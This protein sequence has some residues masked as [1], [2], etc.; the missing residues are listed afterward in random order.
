MDIFSPSCF[1]STASGLPPAQVM[2]ES[3]DESVSAQVKG[4]Q[5]LTQP[6]D[7]HGSQVSHVV[8]TLEG[9]DPPPMRSWRAD[10]TI[11]T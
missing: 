4:W 1:L 9:V 10:I 6:G 11:H 8:P 5:V 2:R 3:D 7:D